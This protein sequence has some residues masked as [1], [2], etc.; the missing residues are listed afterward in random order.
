MVLPRAKPV[1]SES[2][3]APAVP[4]SSVAP[5]IRAGVVVLLL[6]TA[7]PV[8]TLPAL[9]KSLPA[10]TA[11]AAF[12]EVLASAVI[13]LLSAD[14]RFA[15]V[16]AGEPPMAKLLDGSGVVFEAVSWTDSVVPS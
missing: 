3:V 8:A 14:C 11:E 5:V 15:V 2:E 4:D 7:F 6:L 12:S 9:K 10:A 1:P 16:A 13:A